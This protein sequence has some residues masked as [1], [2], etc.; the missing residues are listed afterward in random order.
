M[1]IFTLALASIG[2][3]Y[4]AQE[5]KNGLEEIKNIDLK[6]YKKYNEKN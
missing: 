6:N 1:T 3:Q 5:I 4:T 2:T